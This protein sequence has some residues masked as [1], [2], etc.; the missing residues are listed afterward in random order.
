[1]VDAEEIPTPCKAVIILVYSR[2]TKIA[3]I[4]V[5]EEL[6]T[7]YRLISSAQPKGIAE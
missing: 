5:R 3:I 2:L 7:R 4:S 6:K 1:M